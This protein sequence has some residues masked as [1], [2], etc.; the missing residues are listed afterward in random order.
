MIDNIKDIM[1]KI[2]V[3]WIW[4]MAHLDPDRNEMFSCYKNFD[5]YL[6]TQI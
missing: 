5:G 2:R 6:Q 4:T 1:Y 3:A